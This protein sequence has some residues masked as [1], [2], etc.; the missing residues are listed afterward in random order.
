[1]ACG[2]ASISDKGGAA[3]VLTTDAGGTIFGE[4]GV[5]NPVRIALALGIVLALAASLLMIGVARGQP[6]TLYLDPDS[7]LVQAAARLDGAARADALRLARYP[8]ANWFT[9]G[10]PAQVEG[11]VRTLVDAAQAAGALPVLVA[12]NIPAR[13][14]ALYSAGGAADGAAY[15]AW[16]A[17]FAAGIGDRPAIV[18]LEPD[19]LGVIPWHRNLAGDVESC[20]PATLDPATASAQRFDQLRAAVD[21]LAARPNIRLYLD[22]TT[23]SWLAPGDIATRLIAANVGKARGFF[24]NVSNYEDDTRLAHY[25]R[26]ISDCIAL[27]TRAGLNPRQCPSQHGPAQFDRTESWRRTDQAYDALFRDAGLRRNHLAQ[28]RAVLD[29]SRNGQGSWQPPSARYRDAEVWC[30]PP[31]RGLGRRP[32]LDPGIPYVDALLWIKVPGES[33][34]QCLRG[35][36]GPADPERG[37]VAPPAGGWFADQARELIDRANPPLEP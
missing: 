2:R 20:R 11:K 24:L 34:G 37:R 36:A 8:T 29:T 13:D 18:I 4:G 5:V 9:D 3:R 35:T 14:C 19:G 31:Q 27:V 1:M 10:S 12:Y 16:I 17:G 32:L 30:N 15:R 25:A 21:L 6:R 33:D 23:S 22:G 26:W 7:T 28:K